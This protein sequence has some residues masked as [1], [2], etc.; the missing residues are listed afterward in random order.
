ME[1]NKKYESWD[2]KQWIDLFCSSEKIRIEFGGTKEMYWVNAL[3]GLWNWVIV[4]YPDSPIHDN[5]QMMLFSELANTAYLIQRSESI[6]QDKRRT[7][8]EKIALIAAH[9]KEQPY[10]KSPEIEAATSIN[11]SE[12]R[13]LWNPIKRSL[14]EAKRYKPSG[15]KTE[16]VLEAED[17]S[18]SCIICGDLLSETFH[19]S[20]CDER[21][22]G[23]CKDCHIANSHPL[24]IT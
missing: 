16:G 9:L 1:K 18:A 10:A 21:I 11:E 17:K 13:R 19:C 15:S 5:A 2:V 7:L 14:K 3:H 4:N 6:R 12:V 23:E 8:S 22:I 20:K 24:T